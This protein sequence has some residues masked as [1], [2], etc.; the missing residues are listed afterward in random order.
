MTEQ[1]CDTCGKPVQVHA[2][3][4]SECFCSAE[5]AGAEVTPSDEQLRALCERLEKRVEQDR[6]CAE[7]SQVVADLLAPEFAKFHSRKAPWNTYAV[8]MAVDHQNSVRRDTAFADDLDAARTAI[9]GL[10]DRVAVLREALRPFAKLAEHVATK[11]PGWDH[12]DFLF[13]LGAVNSEPLTVRFAAF[14]RAR[15]AL[16]GEPK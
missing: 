14:R 15:A 2:V 6:S 3:S 7:D 5:C 11:H 13:G 10:L 8:R 1:P 9:P 4:P 12:D 16:Q